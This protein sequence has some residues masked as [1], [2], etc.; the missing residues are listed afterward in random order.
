MKDEKTT[1]A[2][3]IKKVTLTKTPSLPQLKN[4]AI[5][6]RTK[7]NGWASVQIQSMAY[8]HDDSHA[9]QYILNIENGPCE[10]YTTWELCQLAYFKLMSE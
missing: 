8:S 6:L 9:F 10:Y 4:M 1:P 5:N 7:T 3:K 2:N